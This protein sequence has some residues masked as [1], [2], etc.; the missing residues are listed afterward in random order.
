MSEAKDLVNSV[1]GGRTL[2]TRA[3]L[4]AICPRLKTPRL[5]EIHSALNT[6][7][8]KY[9]IE[10]PLEIAAF[11]ATCAHES[12]EFNLFSENLNYSADALLRVF[13]RK[14]FTP[15]LATRYA[16][17]PKAIGSRVY[18]NRMGNGDEKSGEGYF[19]RGAGAIQLTGKKNQG[20][21][22]LAVGM[23]VDQASN[24]LRTPSGG[25]EG[26]CWFW[27]VNKLGQYTNNF[28]AIQ[29]LVNVGRANATVAQI[30]GWNDR[31]KKFNTARKAMGL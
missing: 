1:P 8:D 20:A 12:A 25:V 6:M 9:N 7:L 26:A 27:S 3:Q 13:G 23:P 24:Y 14:Y 29:G 10:S 5:E 22:A 31:L 4:V 16:R 19:Y 2:V 15:E 17:N 18:A 30:V 11:L 28:Q 21:F